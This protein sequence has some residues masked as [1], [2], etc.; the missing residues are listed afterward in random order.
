MSIE[1]LRAL[2][3][4]YAPTAD[5][6]I[7]LDRE[8]QLHLVRLRQQ[9]ARKEAERDRLIS[10]GN[11]P[12]QSLGET[13]IVDRLADEITRLTAE[14]EA[15]QEESKDKSIVLQFKRLPTTPDSADEGEPDYTTL[16]AEFADEKGNLDGKALDA[17]ADRLLPLCYVGAGSA[18]GDTGMTWAEVSRVLDAADRDQLRAVIRGHHRFGAAIPFDP[19]PSGTPETT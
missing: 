1:T 3:L 7:C 19:R 12:S 4:A 10:A 5:Y 18:Y 6:P 17:L 2:A 14:L 9:I 11:L 13:P 16:E 15:V 8:V